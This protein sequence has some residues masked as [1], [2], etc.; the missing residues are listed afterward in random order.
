MHPLDR[1]K[2]NISKVCFP[3]IDSEGVNVLQD[4]RM[5]AEF[6]LQK[7]ETAI[8]TMDEDEFKKLFVK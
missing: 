3:L 7:I 6:Y 8:Q 5:S 4:R 1:R 2:E